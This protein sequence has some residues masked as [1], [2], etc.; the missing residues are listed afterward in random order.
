MIVVLST[1]FGLILWVVLWS[2]NV[3]GFD[4]G[5]LFLLVVLFAAT[6]KGISGLLPGNRGQDEAIPDAAPFN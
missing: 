5:M 3:K 2:L 1:A 4:G 6:I